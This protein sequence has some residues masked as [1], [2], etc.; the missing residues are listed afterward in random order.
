MP[1]CVAQSAGKNLLPGCWDNESDKTEGTPTLRPRLITALICLHRT[2]AQSSSCSVCMDY[3]RRNHEKTK[4]PRSA[5]IIL[6]HGI[7]CR[8]AAILMTSKR[9]SKTDSFR[10]SLEAI[11]CR[12]I[13]L[14][15][16]RQLESRSSLLAAACQESV[17]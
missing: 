15:H 6:Q 5:R 1:V 8:M 17:R 14:Q 9:L 10:C 11:S 4:P 2:S 7:A 16:R 3:E 13:S 12:L